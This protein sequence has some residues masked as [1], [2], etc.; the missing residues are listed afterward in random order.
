MDTAQKF[1]QKVGLRPLAG[2]QYTDINKAIG[3]APRRGAHPTTASLVYSYL[4]NGTV[5]SI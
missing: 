4:L 2:S 3:C 5:T 1:P